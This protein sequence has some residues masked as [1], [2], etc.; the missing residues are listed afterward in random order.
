[1]NVRNYLG[2]TP[3]HLASTNELF[4]EISKNH[5]SVVKLLV[6]NGADVNVKNSSDRTPA[7]K[8]IIFNAGFEVIAYLINN[9]TDLSSVDD[10]FTLLSRSCERR[11][12]RI[13]DLLLD[14][15]IEFPIQQRRLVTL[16]F[17]AAYADQH[18]LFNIL[19]D[20][21]PNILEGIEE[22]LISWTA[23]SGSIKILRQ[24]TNMG[25][26]LHVTNRYGNSL[27]HTASKKNSLPVLQFLLDNGI[28]ID[29]KNS[30]GKTAFHL[31]V[32]YENTEI[33]EFLTH[34]GANQESYVFP[35]ITGPYLGQ[36]PP[37]N[38][39][40]IFAPG[41]VS[42]EDNE[43]SP[44]TFSKDGNEA[45]WVQE[46][47]MQIFKSSYQNNRWS[48]PQKASFNYGLG[49][50]EPFISFDNN[51]LFFLSNRNP[52]DESKSS[53]RERIWYVNRLEDGWSEPICLNEEANSYPMH[54]TISA[55]ME[56]SI[57]FSSRHSSGLGN[58]DI[59]KTRFE[60]G[61]YQKPENLGPVINSE[62]GE[63]TPFIAPDESYLIFSIKNHPEGQ[64]NYDLFISY[65][66]PNKGWSSPKNL[67]N[68]INSSSNELGPIV[69]PDG[70][71]M[72]YIA[73]G[74]IYWVDTSF[75]EK[76]RAEN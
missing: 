10:A 47:P 74:D 60:K 62:L 55:D 24:L 72:F 41:I 71:Y 43:H 53:N 65:N 38:T 6:S 27:I 54:W 52:E 35:N 18:R 15:D 70:N 68:E 13:T 32:E 49:D 22:P 58:Q 4:E 14:K 59:F 73:S 42:I 9:G 45:Y 8:A 23:G 20:K 34:N 56:N 7:L 19:L 50:G 26:S 2:D 46:F 11:Y 76:L 63:G 44:P 33:V 39:L 66:Q 37:S 17:R 21:S 36:S 16:V 12:P 29:E 51:Q 57:Y 61:S 25:L 31:A 69:S 64:G 28:Q 75:I 30:I 3:L 40:K 48:Q 1:M 5:L 67:G